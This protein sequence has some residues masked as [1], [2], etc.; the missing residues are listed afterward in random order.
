VDFFKNQVSFVKKFNKKLEL[1]EALY[2]AVKRI[3][4]LKEERHKPF[5]VKTLIHYAKTAWAEQVIV[6]Q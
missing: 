2:V 6:D 5:D 3:A 4:L 1:M